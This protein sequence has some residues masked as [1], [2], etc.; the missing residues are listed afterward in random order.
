MTSYISARSSQSDHGEL[1]VY[2]VCVGVVF[3]SKAYISQ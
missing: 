1:G 2:I 3:G